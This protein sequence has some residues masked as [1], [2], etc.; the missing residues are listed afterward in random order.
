M[1]NI[2][3]GITS[4]TIGGAERVLVDIVNQL[5]DY[6][7]TIF[8][9]YAK[10]DFEKHLN[11]N[12]KLKS[13]YSKQYNDF[14]RWEKLWISLKILLFKKQIYKKEIKGN[15]DVEV[16]FLEG[17]ITR[18]FSVKNKKT[19]KIAWIHNDISLV[20]GNGI[21]SKIKKSIDKNLYNQYQDI[22]FVSQD[23]LKKFK[24]IY[25]TKANTKVIYNYIDSQNVI[26]KAKETPDICFNKQIPSLLTVARL[27]EQ[28]AIDRFI[29]VHVYLKQNGI[30]H[31]VY[32]IGDGPLKQ[33]LKEQIKKANVEE[34]FH[35]LGK[36][37]NPYPY[38]KMADYFCLFSYFEG[39][40]MV[41]EEAKILGKSILITDTAA[42][43][44]VNNYEKAIIFEN[45]EKRYRK[46]Y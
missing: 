24:T 22:I 45:T 31:N 30:N 5:N 36:R 9:I 15:Y 11:S 39:Y 10:G 37:Q 32:V 27:V 25:K 23:N 20:F 3:F 29:R 4:L 1:K 14:S 26:E 7:I 17:P 12:I 44:A 41:L 6:N 2:I 33:H 16:S 28:K 8:T 18:I 13:L 19:R 38:I 21:K 40:G 42:R 34:T 35:L 43:E 46:W